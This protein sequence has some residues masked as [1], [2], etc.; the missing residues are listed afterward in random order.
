MGKSGNALCQQPENYPHEILRE[1]P[2]AVVVQWGVNDQY[3]GFT[4]AQFA[5]R[6]EQLVQ[7]LHEAKPD[8]TIVLTTLVTDYRRPE[9]FDL[10]IGEANVAIQEI[11]ARY[12]CHVAYVHRA[13][14]HNKSLQPDG[15]HINNAGA[16]AMADA[17]AAAF[18]TP[19]L[20]G[21]N[22]KVQFDHGTEVRFMQYV[23]IPACNGRVPQWISVS[24]ITSDGMHVE[25]LV[26][27]SIRTAPIYHE[28]IYVITI[29]EKSG[30]VIESIRCEVNWNRMLCFNL[31]PSKHEESLVVEINMESAKNGEQSPQ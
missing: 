5:T 16:K 9:N 31:N 3:W 28:G 22:L 2:S 13:L 19:P 6:Y 12:R 26:P 25:T 20:S 8:M 17:I 11:A 24:E 21:E 1:N 15:I 18:V 10:W 30:V 27:V 23:F 4:L 14:N 29:R 7:E